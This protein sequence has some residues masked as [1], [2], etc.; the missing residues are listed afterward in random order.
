MSEAL[1]FIKNFED[2]LKSNDEEQRKSNSLRTVRDALEK[3]INTLNIKKANLE[4]QLIKRKQDFDKEISERQENIERNFEAERK[5][6]AEL[7]EKLAI[8]KNEQDNKE[9]KQKS[10]QSA[11]DERERQQDERDKAFEHKSIDYKANLVKLKEDNER[12]ASEDMR[13]KKEW[14]VIEEE[15]KN[16]LE[17]QKGNEETL[18]EIRKKQAI[19]REKD[20]KQDTKDLEQAQED[21][22]LSQENKLLQNGWVKL[23]EENKKIELEKMVEVK[24]KKDNDD[25]EAA[26][27]AMKIEFDFKVAK[28][29][30]QYEKDNK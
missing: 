29:K 13:Q 1:D 11:Q 7:S 22:R 3:D 15:K 4:Q 25:K 18:A 14:Q 2:L 5:R 28:F 24:R 10:R 20:I 6:L 30:R 19:Q 8:Q 23:G 17:F 9:Q 26:L 27:K 16:N 12:I 21:N